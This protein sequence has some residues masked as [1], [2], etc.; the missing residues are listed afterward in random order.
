ML[1]REA[2]DMRLSPPPYNS[3]IRSIHPAYSHET[4]KTEV[5]F[6][7][8]SLRTVSKHTKRPRPHVKGKENVFTLIRG[9]EQEE[10][11][12]IKQQRKAF[13]PTLHLKLCRKLFSF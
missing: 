4:H 6:Q 3:P 8:I 2:W 1:F 9:H 10:V 11:M 13:F 12:T 5:K 7:A